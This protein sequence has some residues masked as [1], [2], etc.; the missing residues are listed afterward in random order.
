[1]IAVAGTEV[2][3]SDPVL[4][5]INAALL[6]KHGLIDWAAGRFAIG[7]PPDYCTEQLQE[8]AEWGIASFFIRHKGPGIDT[9]GRQLREQIIADLR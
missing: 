9:S 7:R 3:V 2:G 6:D 5:R 1:V 4:G 8:F